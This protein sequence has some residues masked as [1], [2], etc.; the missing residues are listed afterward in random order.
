MP[1]VLEKMRE[2][3]GYCHFLL[4]LFDL[5][6]KK[7][8][9]FFYKLVNKIKMS[10][11]FDGFHG[12]IWSANAWEEGDEVVLITCRLQNPDLDQVNGP[13]KDHIENF[14][15]ELYVSVS[16]WKYCLDSTISSC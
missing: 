8:L 16:Y 14:T 13:V 10:T 9:F 15:N 6:A 1:A 3:F 5:A 4:S 12:Y 2:S 7:Y 11:I